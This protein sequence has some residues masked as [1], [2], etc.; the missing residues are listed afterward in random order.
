ML[1]FV[2]K[3]AIAIHVGD[4]SKNLRYLLW[5][6]KLGFSQNLRKAL[7]HMLISYRKIIFG[8]L[9]FCL[10][11]VPKKIQSVCHTDSYLVTEPFFV[12]TELFS[13]IDF[14]ER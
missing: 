4:I 10:D 3:Q 11:C 12:I 8:L 14:F 1:K 9:N 5:H 13:L 7:T 2:L 6:K